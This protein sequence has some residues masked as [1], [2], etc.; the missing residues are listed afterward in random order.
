MRGHNLSEAALAQ[1]RVFKLFLA[2]RFDVDRRSREV[3]C[4]S[5]EQCEV[6]KLLLEEFQLSKGAS[7]GE[8]E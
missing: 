7:E 6:L 2:L 8:T 3:G 4:T 5:E 1:L